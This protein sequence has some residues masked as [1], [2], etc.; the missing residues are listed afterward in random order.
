M[1]VRRGERKQTKLKTKMSSPLRVSHFLF[2]FC[3]W[4]LGGCHL[5][6]EEDGRKRP[7]EKTKRKGFE[8]WEGDNKQSRVHIH[9]VPMH[10]DEHT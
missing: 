9:L 1:P 2:L 5:A 8:P 4:L 10:N 3:R 7:K 6:G